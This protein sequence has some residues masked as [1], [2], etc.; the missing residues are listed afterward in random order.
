LI[1][2]P[3]GKNCLSMS[4]AASVAAFG[5]PVSDWDCRSNRGAALRGRGPSRPSTLTARSRPK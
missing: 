5:K 2:Y 1:D 4:Q 3:V